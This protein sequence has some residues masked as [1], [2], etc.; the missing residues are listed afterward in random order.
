[1]SLMEFASEGKAA[2]ALCIAQSFL[3]SVFKKVCVCVCANVNAWGCLCLLILL[4]IHL[5]S[6]VKYPSVVENSHTLF[7]FSQ[8]LF[9][10]YRFPG[11]CRK[12]YWEVLCTL[13]S[14]SPS[15]YTLRWLQRG[16]NVRK[17]TLV[18]YGLALHCFIGCADSCPNHYTQ[19]QR[20]CFTTVEN[21]IS[22]DPE[23]VSFETVFSPTEHVALRSIQLLYASMLHCIAK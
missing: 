18:L 11:S 14:I 3:F 5:A 12:Q 10:N 21:V 20:C 8:F 6:C 1:M 4:G 22:I 2:E 13:L 7:P 23:Y 16:S 15:G 17:L 9:G 19:A